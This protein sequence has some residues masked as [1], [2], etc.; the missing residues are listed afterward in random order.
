MAFQT[1]T[2]Q[3][4]VAANTNQ[5]E[6]KITALATS[7]TATCATASG[8]GLAPARSAATAISTKPITTP[9]NPQGEKVRA[10]SQ[11]WL[12][13]GLSNTKSKV[14]VRT[15]V[16]I[17]LKLGCSTVLVRPSSRV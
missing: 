13:I 9:G 6:Y 4:L 1:F 16:T 15:W 3:M 7:S 14:P 8:P 10:E 2:N 12:S 11:N 5:S 17:V